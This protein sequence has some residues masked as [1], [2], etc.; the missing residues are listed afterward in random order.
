MIYTCRSIYTC[1]C[2]CFF[3]IVVARFLEKKVAEGNPIYRHGRHL[4]LPNNTNIVN[5][6]LP[7]FDGK[8]ACGS[9]VKQLNREN[10]LVDAHTVVSIN[11]SA[12]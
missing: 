3:T 7:T 9:K 5:I 10:L 12:N 6:V 2:V 8:A 11:T 4:H 1:V